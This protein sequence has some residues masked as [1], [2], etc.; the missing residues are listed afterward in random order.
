MGSIFL[1]AKVEECPCRLSDLV[2]VIDHLTK[3]FR[4]RP[5][6]P[7]VLFSQVIIVPWTTLHVKLST[8]ET[9]GY[10]SCIVVSA[11]DCDDLG[12]L[13]PQGCSGDSRDADPQETRI[14]RPCTT[15]IRDHGQ[16]LEGARANR[17]PYNPTTGMGVHE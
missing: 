1:A 11:L 3:K 6:D 4:R 13:Q 8:V 16:L 5:V 12:V 17:A 7:L 15:S 10:S 2:N 9:K 14:Q